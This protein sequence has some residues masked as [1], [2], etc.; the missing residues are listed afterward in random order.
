MTHRFL[1]ILTAVVLTGWLIPAQG[2]AGPFSDEFLEGIRHYNREEYPAARRNF[3]AARQAHP[4]DPMI[5]YNL[6]NTYYRL[7]EFESAAETY[8]EAESLFEDPS[9][10]QKSLY[11]RGNALFRLGDVS[12]AI[13][14]YKKALEL[15]PKDVDAKFNL[16]YARM[17][18]E[19]ARQANRLQPR[20]MNQK[21]P[22]PK[23]ENEGQ[24]GDQDS[25]E[26][27]KPSE[28]V[29]ED[30][31]PP[32]TPPDSR[33][34]SRNPDQADDTEPEPGHPA[35]RPPQPGAQP[36]P[37]EEAQ[38]RDSEK[39]IQDIAAMS[40][41][42][43]ERWLNSLHEDLKKF[44]RRQLQGQMEDLFVKGGKDW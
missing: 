7:G 17:L 35:P 4:K 29:E 32:D 24:A 6:A 28:E 23:R 18:K 14:A 27:R 30:D 20:D 15:D 21:A 9:M 22:P 44:S 41:E 1:H 39:A 26:G 2:R 34:A 16:E 11:N 12:S 25:P 10:K 38:K 8:L 13:M 5:A 33:Q 42:E 19:R 36:E 37:R 31:G 43:A 3:E 40:R